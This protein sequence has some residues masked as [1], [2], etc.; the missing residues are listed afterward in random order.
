M[1]QRAS[2]RVDYEWSD[3]FEVKVNRHHGSVLSRFCSCG[4]C[5]H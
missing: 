2:V 1:E 3:K 5:C 4:R